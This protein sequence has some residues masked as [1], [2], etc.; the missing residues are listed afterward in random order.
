MHEKI[1]PFEVSELFN[2]ALI[3]V[4]TPEKAVKSFETTGICPCN[5]DVFSNEDLEPARIYGNI[6]GGNE[7]PILSPPGPSKSNIRNRSTTK[8]QS[9]IMTSTQYKTKN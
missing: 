2:K 7:S 4:A 6:D 8:P 3:K 1:T 9:Q 5:S